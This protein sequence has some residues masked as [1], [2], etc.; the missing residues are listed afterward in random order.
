MKGK[1]IYT[2]LNVSNTE[3]AIYIKVILIG[4]KAILIDDK[5][6]TYWNEFPF[7]KN[8]IIFVTNNFEDMERVDN[9]KGVQKGTKIGKYYLHYILDNGYLVSLKKKK[10]KLFF[11]N[12]NDERL[13]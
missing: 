13:K 11:I 7:N 1:L 9:I 6:N 2:V 8:D 12:K 5:G 3:K 10:E 4:D